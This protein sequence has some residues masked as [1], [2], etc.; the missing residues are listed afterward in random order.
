MSQKNYLNGYVCEGTKR[1]ADESLKYEL[2]DYA[3][4]GIRLSIRGRGAGPDDIALICSVREEDAGY[5]RDYVAGDD[6]I[7]EMIDFVRIKGS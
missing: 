2:Q 3:R 6:G 7:I 4:K 5:M 1:F